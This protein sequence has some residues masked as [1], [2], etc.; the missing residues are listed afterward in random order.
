MKIIS[1]IKESDFYDT[2]AFAKLLDVTPHWLHHNRASNDPIPNQKIGHR[3]IRY[4][5]NEVMEWMG[6]KDLACVF[7]STKTLAKKMKVSV[8]WLKHNRTSN[9]PIPF[10][11]FGRLIRYQRDEVANWLRKNNMNQCV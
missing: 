10:R 3:L 4:N 2:K 9:N 11:R 8:A 6:R 7:F 1:D 5:T